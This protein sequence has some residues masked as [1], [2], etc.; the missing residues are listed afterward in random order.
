MTLWVTVQSYR[1]NLNPACLLH[2]VLKPLRAARQG[3]D[4]CNSRYFLLVAKSKP[5]S[6][7]PGAHN[8]GVRQPKREADYSSPTNTDVK[9]TQS[10]PSLTVLCAPTQRGKFSFTVHDF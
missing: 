6:P 9:N 10:L 8:P 5:Q 2:V 4:F 3:L 1:R 7:A